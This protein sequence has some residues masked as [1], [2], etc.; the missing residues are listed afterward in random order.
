MALARARGYQPVT[1]SLAPEDWF[2]HD[3]LEFDRLVRYLENRLLAE[4]LEIAEIHL[5]TCPECR[6]DVR[7][8]RA[9]RQVTEPELKIVYGPTAVSVTDRPAGIW[10]Q[11]R[12]FLRQP[13]YG[14]LALLGVAVA[15]LVLWLAMGRNGTEQ[16]RV[17]P[18]ASPAT[19]H[20][21]TANTNSTGPRVG[22]TET[23]ATA[24]ATATPAGPLATAAPQPQQTRG[25]GKRTNAIT[26][27]AASPGAKPLGQVPAER[28]HAA[29]RARNLPGPPNPP[30]AAA[31]LPATLRRAVEETLARQR[32]DKPEI[33]VA[34]ESDAS[35]LRGNDPSRRTFR[36]LTPGRVVTAET[37][38]L[39]GWEALPG[40]S[41]YQ[42]FVL[43]GQ[44]RRVLSSPSLPATQTAWQPPVPLRAGETYSWAVV[45]SVD[46]EEVVAPAASAPEARFH[47]LSA[48]QAQELAW[49]KKGRLT[50][51]A[52]GII[53]AR[54]GLLDEAEKEFRLAVQTDP[55]S[56]VANKLLR[57]VQGW[58]P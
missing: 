2:R 16:A 29:Q 20:N 4:D 51:L 7:V 37:R 43:D 28:P 9:Y 45:A 55:R 54:A 23:P 14:V 18:L 36:L 58:R 50:P 5:R 39:F 11:V 13:A 46:G 52:R 53:Y 44:G 25:A 1:F 32:L 30:T 48:S 31:A 21:S 38:P 35:G 56:D 40:A 12:G 22:T 34:L 41:G 47:V 15:G 42:V 33:L 17:S 26:T 27:Q 19:S 49:L 3:H 10:S 6:E 57:Q 24:A 8:M